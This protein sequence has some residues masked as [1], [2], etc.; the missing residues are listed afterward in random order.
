MLDV[1][2]LNVIGSVSDQV[3]INESTIHYLM[4]RDFRRTPGCMLMYKVLGKTIVHRYDV[5]HV[6]K[7]VRNNF[8]E[9]DLQH[10]INERWNISNSTSKTTGRQQIASWADVENLYQIDRT[11]FHRLLPKITEQHINPTKLKMRVCVAT[12][13]FSQTYGTV[14][15]HCAENQ[16]LPSKSSATAQI[17]LFFNDLFDSLNGS[18]PTQTGS[19]EGSINEHSVHFVFWE[20]ALTMLAKMKFV[21]KDTGK[22]NTRSSVLYKIQSTIKGYQE[23]ARICL[24]L[25]MKDVSLRYFKK[26]YKNLF[27]KKWFLFRV[28][29]MGQ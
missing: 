20:Y 18:G 8:R 28:K 4:D 23:I 1:L 3:M 6:I 25:N 24:N 13:V 26:I 11:G 19:L 22:I 17:L 21:D 27:V 29:S 9:K 15:L 10:C 16:Q 12:Q 2:G 7:V 5:P 14:M